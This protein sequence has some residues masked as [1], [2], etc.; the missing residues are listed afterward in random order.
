M[1]TPNLRLPAVSPETNLG[2]RIQAPLL[3]TLGDP[4]LGDQRRV[5]TT[6]NQRRGG[7]G[8][9]RVS[10][11]GRDKAELYPMCYQVSCCCCCSFCCCCCCSFC[12]CCCCCCC[13]CDFTARLKGLLPDNCYQNILDTFLTYLMAEENHN[14]CCVF[15][16]ILPNLHD[17]HP[18]LDYF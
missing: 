16:H 11:W 8:E 7:L 14:L 15:S 18:L 12:C 17:L 10:T 9:R 13:C 2:G 5:V 1:F 6:W 4:R 3:P